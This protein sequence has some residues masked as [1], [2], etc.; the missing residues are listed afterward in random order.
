VSAP[1]VLFADRRYVV[2]NKPAG[3]AS[4]AGPRGGASAEDWFGPLS[5][6]RD[7]PWLAHRLDA[8]TAGCLVVALRKTALLEA[9]ALFAAGQVEKVYWAVVEGRPDADAGQVAD[10]LVKRNGPEGWRMVRDGGGQAAV[11]DWRLAGTDGARSW[12]ELRPRTGRTHQI[13]VHCAW[14]GCPIVGDPIYGTVAAGGLQ[15]LAR[16]VRVPVTPAVYAVAPVPV[17]MQGHGLPGGAFAGW[18]E[19]GARAAD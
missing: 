5:R 11:T 12:L 8:D 15:L 18:D 6:R 9:Q 4:H 7:G 10:R 1:P 16:S 13:R 17:H 14:L 3:L 2:L 19:A